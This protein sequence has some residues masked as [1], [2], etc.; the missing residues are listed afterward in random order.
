MYL[1]HLNFGLNFNFALHFGTTYLCE[2]LIL[3][4][5]MKN[6]KW[7]WLWTTKNVTILALGLQQR[8][9]AWKNERARVQLENHVHTLLSVWEC[10][11]MNPR[12]P[13]WVS[14][15]RGG[16]PRDFQMF[17]EQFEGSKLIENFLKHKCLKW[18][19]M[20]HLNTY[21]TNYGLKKGWE[22]NYQFNSQPLK[23]KSCPKLGVCR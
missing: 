4:E 1:N 21:N 22:S 20:I 8:Q 12:I 6:D 18:V 7:M 11:G 19:H 2:F 3:I 15:L 16:D 17:K 23:V 10:E 13:K 5:N 9:R 14:T